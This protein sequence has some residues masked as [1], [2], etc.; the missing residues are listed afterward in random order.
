MLG[1]IP[2]CTG[3]GGGC[4]GVGRSRL[5]AL[6]DTTTYILM[7]ADSITSG[8]GAAGADRWPARLEALL[9]EDVPERNIV[10]SNGQVRG[11]LGAALH[12]RHREARGGRAQGGHR[13]RAPHARGGAFTDKFERVARTLHV[14]ASGRPMLDI[15]KEWHERGAETT[16]GFYGDLIQPNAEDQADI[17]QR[18]RAIL[19]ASC[20]RT[21]EPDP[22]LA[23]KATAARPVAGSG[24]RL[25]QP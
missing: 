21:R 11:R 1:T 7:L 18:A 2:P 8:E 22:T 25:G 16:A 14:I 19:N 6:R 10:V 24:I 5:R 23:V 3:C 4:R 17:A 9:R 15:A 13:H 20:G 12:C